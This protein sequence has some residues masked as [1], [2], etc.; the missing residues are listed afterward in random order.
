[1][2]KIILILI[3]SFFIFNSCK[4]DDLELRDT[5]AISTATFPVN[6]AELKGAVNAAYSPLQSQGLYGRYLPFMYDYMG[7]D[8]EVLLA[9]TYR[10]TPDLQDF[11]KFT[12][13]P[14]NND[15]YL[16]W[17]NAYNGISRANFI[18]DKQDNINAISTAEMPDA[19]KNK[20][21]GEA[22]FLRAL[23]YFLL[24]ER[25]G[26][27]PFYTTTNVSPN[28]LP[29]SPKEDVYQLIIADLN[30]AGENL[31]LKSAAEVGRATSGAAYALLG[32]VHLYRGEHALAKI[33]LDKVIN[34]MEYVLTADYFDN[35]KVETENNSE[36]VFEVQFTYPGGSAWA[37]ADWGGQDNGDSESS[38]RSFEY[39]GIGGWHNNDPSQDLLDEFETGDPRYSASFYSVGDT[40]NNGSGVVDASHMGETTAIWKKY[41]LS[42]K[43]GTDGGGLSDINHRVIRYADVL[44]MAAEVENELGN[45]STAIDYLNEVRDRATMPN[46][47]TAAMNATFPVSNMAEVFTAVVHERRIELAGEQSR[48]PDLLRWNMTN[49]I[50]D[51]NAHNN[52]LPIPQTEIDTNL[53]ISTADQ[54][55]G[56]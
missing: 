17:K 2:K 44:L 35:F 43:G 55:S 48:F 31:N 39:G 32:K 27:I 5:G 16:Y 52:L 11:I 53:N 40:Y 29:K 14:T 24:V 23:N 21:I 25:F 8:C 50:N 45:R 46:Y 22:K 41:E 18:L 37:Y 9:G 26:D 7:N 28:G 19:L 10:G 47:D 20:Y 51:F 54:N 36:S 6:E 13:T 3:V 1:M 34:S 56:Y 38:F 15:I 4:T 33:A 42:Y 12:M 30:F 49:L